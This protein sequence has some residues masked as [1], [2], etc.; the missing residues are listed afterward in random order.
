MHP[1]VPSMPNHE[2]E[3]PAR[4]G[5]R[6]LTEDILARFRHPSGPYWFAVLVLAI[7]FIAG[8]V[9]FAMRLSAG[10]PNTPAWGYY[11]ATFAYL[12]STVLAVPIIIT[13]LQFTKAAW[14]RPLARPALLFAVP[15]VLAGLMFLPLLGTLPPL[16]GRATIWFNWP[17]GFLR[18]V[19]TIAILA[20][21]LLGLVLL[22]L[23]GRPDWA[24]M[25]DR[26][27]GGH[28]GWTARLAA[29]WRGADREW[30]VL[31]R[32]F[33]LLGAFYI[34]LYVFA[35]FLISIDFDLS[36]IPGW[37]S[38]IYPTYHIV[39]SVQA[40]I[41]TLLVTIALLRRFAGL[42]SYL[43][44]DQFWALGKLQLGFTL[45]WF[46]FF[47]SGFIVIWYGRMPQEQSLLDITEFGP[48]LVPFVL[49]VVFAFAVP[50][51]LLIWNPI[52]KS[53]IGPPLAGASILIGLFF[54][55]VRLYVPAYS[56]AGQGG[57]AAGEIPARRLP[58]GADWLM[59]AGAFAGVVLLYLLSM[60]VLPVISIWQMK[61]SAMLR[62]TRR[63][64][65][66]VVEV[67]G[68]PE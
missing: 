20:V 62:E 54:D 6:E 28:R 2:P 53:V 48:Y 68:K 21:V 24:A 49:T 47:W 40:A 18:W 4:I 44:L 12:L 29:D 9:G 51:V 16:Q 33:R 45:L 31:D 36:L 42:G 59:I 19:D 8:I 35:T 57:A 55:R 65:R 66:T 7:V 13:G 37:R 61:V 26:G 25:R 22:Y 67:I 1:R 46:Y 64:L 5:D 34:F 3:M 14:I 58:D 43:R 41:A 32:G 60:R 50:F 30:Q 10:F 63:F 52:R 15:G 39:T 23:E 11:A 17:I 56:I 27:A 38:P